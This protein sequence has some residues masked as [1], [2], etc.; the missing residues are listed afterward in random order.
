MSG[1]S[2]VAEGDVEW[3]AGKE[4]ENISKHG[5]DFREAA[6]VFDDPLA[7]TDDD[8]DHSDEEQRFRTIGYS[9]RENLLRVSHTYRNKRIRIINAYD[10]TRSER[11]SYEED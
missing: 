1:D 7:L 6:T 11:K 3:D 9:A 8:P 2:D 5:Y 10:P 4:A